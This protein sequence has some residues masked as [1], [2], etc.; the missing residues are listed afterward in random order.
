[1]VKNIM[2]NNFSNI[3]TIIE[4]KDDFYICE[5]NSRRKKVKKASSCLIDPNI[6]DKVYVLFDKS[7][8]YII[9]ILES[10]TN[11]TINTNNLSINSEKLTITSDI[12][13]MNVTNFSSKIQSLKS[14]IKDINIFASITNF[15]FDKFKTISKIKY[16]FS[17]N[18]INQYQT[19][20]TTINV[21][22]TKDSNIIRENTNIE[23]K[24]VNSS[25]TKASQQ[26]KL[27]AKNINLG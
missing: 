1:M 18:R 11:L 17:K 5:S 22:E 25:F 6:G 26:I 2:V 9:H 19:L 3:A 4:I 21:L 7:D 12:L 10:N 16:D 24:N 14:F 13:T 23:H 27:D 15:T 20:K 8:G